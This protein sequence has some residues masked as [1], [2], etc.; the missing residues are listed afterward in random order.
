[1]AGYDDR[2][3]FIWMDGKLVDWRSRPTCISLPTRCITPHP[4][5]KANVATTA[6][7]F[8]GDRTLAERLL[9]IG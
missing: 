7:I 4:S 2:D 1:M 3:G 6:S 8:K 5:S 9:H